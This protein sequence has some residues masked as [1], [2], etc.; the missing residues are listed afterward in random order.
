MGYLD[1]H[2]HV[3][4]ALDDGAPDAAT[5][6]ALV[7][8]LE[9]VGYEVV[10]A[11]PHQRAGLYLPSA[12]AIAAAHA[13]LVAQALPVRLGLAAENYWDDVFFQRWRD[14]TIPGY[15]A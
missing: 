7:N 8:M 13:A 4:P 10:T 1:L 12:E 3:L 5:G 15:G 9:K 2:A 6:L 14:G 11:T